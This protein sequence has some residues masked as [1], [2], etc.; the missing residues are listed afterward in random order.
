MQTIPKPRSSN[1]GSNAQ[2]TAQITALRDIPQIQVETDWNAGTVEAH[3]ITRTGVSV[4]IYR[5]VQK[6]HNRPW[7]VTHCRDLFA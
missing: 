1:L 2:V 6:G 3:L 5:A 7:L 4:P